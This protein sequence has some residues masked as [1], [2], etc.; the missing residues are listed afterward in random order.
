MK[1]LSLILFILLIGCKTTQKVTVK[2]TKLTIGKNIKIYEENGFGKLGPCE[3]SIFI[4]PK[5]TNQIVA[6]S[7]I[8]FVHHSS[9]G[10]K[11]WQTKSLTSNLGVYGDPCIVADNQ[12]A[13]YY[14]HLS[15]PD[16]YAYGSKRFL[17]RMV[18]HKSNDGGKTWTDGN[19]IGKHQF[20]K[21]QDKEW[22]VVNP[23]N[24]EIYL[25]WTEFDKYAS[26]DKNHHS[27]ILF[28]KSSDGSKTWSKTK[29]LSEIEGNALDDDKTVEG[30]VPAVGL[31][32]EIYV[33]WSVNNKIYFDK[34]LDYGKTWL[35]NDISVCMQPY[36][37]NFNVPGFSRVNGM[38]ITSVDLSNGKHKGTIYINF[39]D[40]R[41]GPYNTDIFLVKSTDN[42][43]TWSIPKKVNTDTTK[44]H[45]FFTWMSVDPK[46]GFIYIVFY[47]RSKYKDNQTDVVLAVSKDGGETFSN[48][49]I[50]KKPFIPNPNVFFGDYNNISAYNG[51][52]RPIW[53]AYYNNKLSVWTCL[54]ED[55]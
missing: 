31:N 9:D 19:G 25:T 12:G 38:P 3:P 13:F 52:V 51:V 26:K 32:G 48:H 37:W 21:Q 46:T 43:N 18:V 17:D 5:N 36:G 11:T 27:R 40:Q 15:N 20:P 47:D 22:A 44:T 6:G 54:I 14:F 10:G 53:T 30:A 35:K 49:T 28:S 8:D 34:S 55:L 29:V 16:G 42:G 1:K 4:N 2:K 41:N 33:S 23:L 50:S 39:S 24:N 45:Q 7:V